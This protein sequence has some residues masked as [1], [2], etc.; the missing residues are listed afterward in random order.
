M[1]GVPETHHAPGRDLIGNSARNPAVS[2]DG[3][4]VAFELGPGLYRVQ[5]G[6]GPVLPIVPDGG[7]PHWF[8]DD[9]IL[10]RANGRVWRVSTA[11]GTPTALAVEAGGRPFLLPGE[12]G[13]LG[14]GPER[15]NLMK[16]AGDIPQAHFLKF[17]KD[18]AEY[19]S[20][21]PTADA[22]VHE[23][24]ESAGQ[25]VAVLG[26][27]VQVVLQERSTARGVDRVAHREV[28]TAGQPDVPAVLR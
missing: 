7:N 18:R 27:G 15:E 17:T 1:E 24:D 3:E 8:A 12:R 23:G 25:Q 21:L 13:V 22:L 28:I 6:G 10:Y 16:L 19:A 9:E 2:P 5:I 4:W 14:D 26:A 11:G 20:I